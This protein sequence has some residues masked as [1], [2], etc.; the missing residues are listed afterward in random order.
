MN[1]MISQP[2]ILIVGKVKRFGEHIK[3]DKIEKK[4]VVVSFNHIGHDFS[5]SVYDIPLVA[6]NSKISVL[7]KFIVGDEVAI[8]AIVSGR[9][10]EKGGISTCF[11]DLKIINI[12]KVEIP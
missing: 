11:L 6:I 1:D 9:D 10:R 8:E 7:N 12:Q 5:K 4:T 2:I 3:N